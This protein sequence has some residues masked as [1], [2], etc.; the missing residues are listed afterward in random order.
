[1]AFTNGSNGNGNGI[2][3]GSNGQVFIVSAART[4]IGKFGG[5]LADVPATTLGAIVIRA[6][7]ERAGI[8]NDAVDEVYMG[9][10]IQAGR[11]HAPAPSGALADRSLDETSAPQIGRG[12]FRT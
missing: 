5:S 6:A 2:G 8:A 3:N 1:M 4:P 12:H 10:A 11:G 9:Q 7:V